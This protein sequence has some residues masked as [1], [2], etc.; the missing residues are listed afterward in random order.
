[1]ADSPAIV[2]RPAAIAARLDA[3]PATRSIWQLV[4]LLS[5]GG[6]FEFYD[7]IL[8]GYAT[9]G[10][11][12]SGIFHTGARGL[13]GMTDQAA[14]ASATFL[15]LFFGTL[16]L[17]FA[18]DR[19]GRRSIF[20]FSLL[21]YAL[22]TSI[23]A[24]QQSALGVDLWRFIAGV[25]IGV[26][27]VTIDSY[28]SELVPKAVRGKAF[29]V[30]QATQFCAVP[31]VAFLAWKL[32]PRDPMGFAGWR[33]LVLIPAIG[34]LVVWW[35]RL[36]VP[37]S[38][39]WL[40]EHDRIK[41]AERVIAHLE[42]AVAED[43]ARGQANS[44]VK[45]QNSKFA[46]IPQFRTSALP[47]FLGG[48]TTEDRRLTADK[49]LRAIFHSPYRSR[50]IMLI[51][52]NFFQSIG[53][54]GF[55]NWVPTLIAS[56]GI[57]LVHSLQYSFII[58]IAFPIS[59]LLFLFFSDRIERKWQIVIAAVGTAA[60]GLGFAQQLRAALLITFGLLLTLSNNL[61]SYSY[62][63]YQAEL[64]PTRLRARAVGVVYSF[65]RISTVFSSFAIG[66]LLE[67]FGSAAVF[68]FIAGAMGIV[69]LAVAPFGPR[70]SKL[71]LEE[72]SH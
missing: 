6:A 71:A 31:I 67:R 63:T 4:V 35:I 51:V 57:S 40:V 66:F 21:W 46:T 64:F 26:E 11:I 10:L 27:L 28:I 9:P 62:H 25:G 42:A 17:G 1:M 7:L 19:F 22:A 53:Y 32:I 34:A 47:Q 50:T 20:T 69:V 14:F 41:Q 45:S 56:R 39:R 61:L 18:A 52:L 5:I 44:K 15:G 2:T 68:A 72:I 60:I 58:A 70:T 29:A 55:N 43:L 16:L 65:S 23:M 36:R 54:Y 3:L 59:P 38:P 8:T 33:W 24:A 48:S 30:N 13:F 37:E 12:R 49:R